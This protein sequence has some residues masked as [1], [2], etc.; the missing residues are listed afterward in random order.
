VPLGD[1]WSYRR[2]ASPFSGIQEVI[3]KWQSRVAA[4]SIFAMTVA[5]GPLAAAPASWTGQISDA[6]CHG[7]HQI[8]PKTCVDKC[9]KGGEKYVLVVQDK[10]ASKVYAISNQKFADLAKFAGQTAVVTGD[11]KDDSITVTKIA[12]PKPAK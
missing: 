11:M 3:M 8:D 7:V 5:S 1:D 6:M 2:A 9:I 10:D 12:A 4:A